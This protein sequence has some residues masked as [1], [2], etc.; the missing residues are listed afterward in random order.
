MIT[1][2]PVQSFALR[3]SAGG[4]IQVGGMRGAGKSTLAN[5]IAAQTA[6][7]GRSCLLVGSDPLLDRPV[8]FQT[9]E[10]MHQVLAERAQLN[11][12]S[13]ASSPN[14]SARLIFPSDLIEARAKTDPVAAKTAVRLL[15]RTRELS[16]R[17]KLNADEIEESIANQSIAPEAF[18]LA[19][20]AVQDASRLADEL[21]TGNG[22][23]GRSFHDLKELLAGAA[24]EVPANEQVLKLILADDATFES[25][26][27]KILSHRSEQKEEQAIAAIVGDLRRPGS[28][29]KTLAECHQHAVWMSR[30]MNDAIALVRKHGSLKAA[31]GTNPDSDGAKAIGFFMRMRPDQGSASAIRAFDTALRDYQHDS[32]A[33]E[34]QLNQHGNRPVGS[35]TAR[36]D[37]SGYKQETNPGSFVQR[38]REARYAARQLPGLL[39]RI[40]ASLPRTLGQR[41]ESAPIE[42]AAGILEKGSESGPRERAA[43]ELRQLRALFSQTGFGDPLNAPQDFESRIEKASE[44]KAPAKEPASTY[45]AEVLDLLLDLTTYAEHHD[46]TDWPTSIVRAK[47]REEIAEIVQSGRRFDVVVVDDAST[48]AHEL[49]DAFAAGGAS[50]H[51]IGVRDED[52]ILLD[53]PH[54]QQDTTVAGA[55]SGQANRWLGAPDGIGLIVRTA[56]DLSLEQLHSAADR[57]VL[58]L[59]SAGCSAATSTSD[60]D[61]DLIVASL[62][63]LGDTN[64]S[65]LVFRHGIRTPFSG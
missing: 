16:E 53:V 4:S 42:D 65:P 12:R 59:R 32:A 7:N 31:L 47:N 21:W 50:V 25:A 1:L 22:R 64:L 52:A 49:M 3:K 43:G 38:I 26:L 14:A 27:L 33:L 54:R 56:P 29:D 19:S 5:A 41:F 35:F 10:R 23:A 45:N 24:I 55:V 6:R 2:D 62:D 20:L 48:V 63:Q 11:S 15:R 61:A 57:L 13:E 60:T 58:L 51:R 40:R 18:D 46:L 17:Y 9:L 30:I 34:Q 44:H 36:S 39:E 8:A 28:P 37:D